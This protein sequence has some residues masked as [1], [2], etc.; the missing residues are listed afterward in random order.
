VSAKTDEK[1]DTKEK[2]SDL[3]R[4]KKEYLKK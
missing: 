3:E 1:K 4:Q 2:I